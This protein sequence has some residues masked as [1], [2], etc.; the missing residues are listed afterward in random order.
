MK[1]ILAALCLAILTASAA[2]AQTDDYKKAEFYVG[3]SHQRVDNGIGDDD[4]LGDFIKDRQGF[5]GFEAAAVYNVSRYFGIKG[6][7]SGAYN[8]TSYSFDIP[9]GPTTSGRLS[10]D[11][12][13]SVYNFLGGVQVKDNSTETRFKPFAHALV[14]AGHVR[15]KISNSVCPTGADC[16]FLNGSAG[17]TGFAGAFGGGLDIKINNKI[18]FRAIQVDYNP[19]RIDG[20]TYNNVRFGVGVVF[21]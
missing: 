3:Y 6:D 1:N 11:T 13:N 15:S 5:N 20:Q 9:T 18:D 21:K 17:E 2:F 14:G 10:F 19:I 4:D 8:S 7:I 16:S 12:K